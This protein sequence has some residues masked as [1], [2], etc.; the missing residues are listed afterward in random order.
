MKK[1]L[2]VLPLLFLACSKTVYVP[3]NSA[4]YVDRVVKDTVV[5]V[6]LI[7]YHDS[8]TTIDTSSVLENK[9]ARSSA[10]WDGKL[11]HS[12]TVKSVP[13]PVKLKYIE[14]HITDT[15]QVPYKLD[16]IKEIP[17]KL[18][19]YQRVCVKG[20]SVLIIS[21]MVYLLVKFRKKLFF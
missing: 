9:Y 18:N 11:H 8:I 12:L 7:P 3:V 14:T 19:W 10:S 5:D 17:A 1:I 13:I 21:I 6:H 16:V 20:F 4:H 15:I 2:F